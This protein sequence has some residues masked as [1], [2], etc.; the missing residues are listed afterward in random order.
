MKQYRIML[1]LDKSV[2]VYE[3]MHKVRTKQRHHLRLCNGSNSAQLLAEISRFQ[4]KSFR[5]CGLMLCLLLICPLVLSAA[6]V[7]L[8]PGDTIGPDNWQRVHGMVGENLLRRIKQGYT[9]KIKQPKYFK[10]P[11][12]YMEATEKYSKAVR[13]GRNGELS[14]YIAG[15]PFPGLDPQDPQAGLK[16]AWNFYWRW[17]GDDYK[18]GAGTNRGRLIRT[19]IEKDGSERRFDNVTHNINTRSRVTLSPKPGIPGYEHI[20][21]MQLLA[22]EYPRDSAGTTILEIRYADTEREDDFYIY[23]PGIRRVRRGP[24][25]QRCETIAGAEHNYDDVNGFRGKITNFK[26][27]FLGEKRILANFSQEHLP[28]RRKAGDYL[29]LD[30]SWEMRDAYVLEITPK[31]PSYCYSKKILY[32]DKTTFESIW[33]LGWD[34]TGNYWREHVGFIVPVKLPDGQEVWSYG[35]V[36]ST[37]MQNGR[38]TVITIVRAFNQ[39]YQPSL[40]TLTT[41]QTVMRGGSIR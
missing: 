23:V 17:W 36:I 14:N 10:P 6:D 2:L 28:L 25:I 1:Y 39:G 31:D 18:D 32:I 26:Y 9:F 21:W 4:V 13:L 35:T 15:L 24:P 30:E 11:R 27:N 8:K 22:S 33:S 34:K 19:I 5:A 12:E 38:S 29:P 40:F 3:G 16:L 41:L 37:N 7:D 20:E